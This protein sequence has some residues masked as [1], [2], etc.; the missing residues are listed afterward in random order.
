MGIAMAVAYVVLVRDFLRGPGWLRGLIFAQI[1]G[2]LQLFW[3]LPALGHG[4][5][6]WQISAVTPLLAW[7]LNAL[8]GIVMG[9]VAELLPTS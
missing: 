7:S 6:G 5:G 1:P 8:Y 4:I 3:V 2:I 9:W